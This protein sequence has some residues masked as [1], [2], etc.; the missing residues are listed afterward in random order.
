MVNHR[1]RQTKEK[2]KTLKQRISSLEGNV[3]NHEKHIFDL[4]DQFEK[5]LEEERRSHVQMPRS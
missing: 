2:I 4:K 5:H 1:T 3:A